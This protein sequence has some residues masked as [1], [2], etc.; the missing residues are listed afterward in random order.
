[1]CWKR[2]TVIKRIAFVAS[3]C[4]VFLLYGVHSPAILENNALNNG[5]FAQESE[6]SQPDSPL[7]VPIGVDDAAQPQSPLEELEAE[8]R[9]GVVEEEKIEEEPT[10]T[11]EPTTTPL[12]TDTPE[13]TVT[14]EPTAVPTQTPT[15]APTESPSATP[16]NTSVA[17]ATV[18]STTTT[19]TTSVSLESTDVLTSANPAAPVDQ[20]E[21]VVTE[22]AAVEVDR[23]VL[24]PSITSGSTQTPSVSLSQTPSI[25]IATTSRPDFLTESMILGL[26]CV[27]ALSVSWLGLCA[28]SVCIFYI[29]SRQARTIRDHSPNARHI[30]VQ[31]RQ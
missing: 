8:G 2:T 26:L 7:D 22:D 10:A 24:L 27:I 15:S 12:P 17:T 6:Q 1:M 16:T 3:F 30:S 4:C 20:A 29:R 5:L 25:L 14:S 11:L 23:V 31:Y 28:L 18:V 21:D 19:S 13:P 9:A